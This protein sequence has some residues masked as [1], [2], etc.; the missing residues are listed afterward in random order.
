MRLVGRGLDR[1]GQTVEPFHDGTLVGDTEGER[2]RLERITVG[3]TAALLPRRVGLVTW[4][5][6]A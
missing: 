3:F 6:S 4:R 2:G 5:R 1:F